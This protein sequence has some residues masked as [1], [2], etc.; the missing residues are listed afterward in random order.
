MRGPPEGGHYVQMKNTLALQPGLE[1]CQQELQHVLFGNC[2]RSGP[3]LD[4]PLLV[5]RTRA[6]RVADAAGHLRR[7]GSRIQSELDEVVTAAI[8]GKPEPVARREHGEVVA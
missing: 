2:V 8:R 6:A 5:D 1:R 7:I 3:G 4:W